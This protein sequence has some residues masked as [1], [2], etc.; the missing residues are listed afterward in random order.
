[1]FLE[2]EITPQLEELM[3]H[4]GIVMARNYGELPDESSGLP[5][6]T[7]IGLSEA[8]KDLNL[9]LGNSSL[10]RRPWDELRGKRVLDLGA[11][12][13][14]SGSFLKRYPPCFARICAI[15][16]AEVIAI[17]IHPQG[18]VDNQLFTGVRADLVEVVFGKGLQHHPALKDKKFDL[19][20]SSDF[21]GLNSSP[22]LD[23]QLL[24][25][26]MFI[27]IFERRLLFQCAILLA[28]GGIM[29]LDIRGEH[30]LPIFYRKTNG[31]I[32]EAVYGS[33]QGD[34][35]WTECA[36]WTPLEF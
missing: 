35:K 34:A 26:N 18:E 33:S 16:G 22:D 11:G 12:S 14:H 20:H 25:E 4:A 31:E 8:G 2:G 13:I 9:L 21:V 10:D 15:N 29:T 7:I 19:I 30:L 17:D 23:R 36:Q 6:D 28:E 27:D 5:I 1:M 32:E 3:K 24:N